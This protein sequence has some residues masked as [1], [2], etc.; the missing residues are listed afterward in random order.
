MEA[1]IG[2]GVPFLDRLK[3][4][5][6]ILIGVVVVSYMGLWIV[7]NSSKNYSS[8]PEEA[9]AL[10]PPAAYVVWGMDADAKEELLNGGSVRFLNVELVPGHSGKAVYLNG[11]DSYIQTFINFKNWRGFTISFWVKPEHKE[12]G[13]LAVILDNGHDAKNNFALQSADRDNPN[14]GRWVF[15]CNGFDI[16]L[17]IP[18]ERWTHV[19]IAADTRKGIIWAY[20][21]GIKAGEI[22]TGKFRLGSMPLTVGR[23]TRVNERYFRGSIDE[24]AIWDRTVK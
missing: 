9:K 16:P 14:S 17:R 4:I 21:D 6:G 15:H 24:L 18:L 11:R 19:V 22:R 5:Y 20:T 2:R 8:T 3:S 23:L 12:G 10:A 13:G 1:L 7:S